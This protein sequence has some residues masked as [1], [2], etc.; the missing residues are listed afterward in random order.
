MARNPVQSAAWR[1]HKFWYPIWRTAEKG[2]SQI[3]VA[4]LVM[5]KLKKKKKR[6]NFHLLFLIFIQKVND[7]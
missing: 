6:R 2:I 5:A 4:T 7:K 3:L 1:V